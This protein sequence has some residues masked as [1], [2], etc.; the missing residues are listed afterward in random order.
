[1][2]KKIVKRV[3]MILL[4]AGLSVGMSC[5]S[6]SAAVKID[7][8]SKSARY[9][10]PEEW[11]KEELKAYQFDSKDDYANYVLTGGLHLYNNK[12]KGKDGWVKIKIADP[13]IFIASATSEED[14]KIPLY[15]ASKT[16]VLAKDITED[17]EIAGYV[18]EVKA[19]DEFYIKLPSKIKK[20]VITVGVIKDQFTSMEEQD[21]Y[22]EAGKGTTSYHTFSIRKRSE[23]VLSIFAQYKNGGKV[24]ARIEKYVNGKWTKIGYTANIKNRSK[25]DLSYG[26]EAGKYRVGLTIPKGQIAQATYDTYTRKKKFAYKKSKAQSLKD[27]EDNI[28]TQGEKA[29][30]WYKV[31]VQTTKHKNQV[32]VAKDSVGGGYK[33]SVY[34]KGKKKAVKTVKVKKNERYTKITL[35]KKKGTYYIKVSKLTD[36]TNGRYL[37]E[38]YTY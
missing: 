7:Q 38:D 19:G 1:M 9:V 25:D 17:D 12:Y 33:F 23:T 16:K 14:D 27:D 28:Y 8:V 18:K 36:K 34:Q 10:Q 37:V 20:D 22:L 31:S 11:N 24:S 21:E 29:A 2:N 15:N 6:V 35:P 13:G 3:G 5:P 26:L 4:A 30:R 32:W